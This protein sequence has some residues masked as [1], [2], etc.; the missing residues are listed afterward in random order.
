VIHTRPL[1]YF[2][3]RQI[4]VYYTKTEVRYRQ[5][6]RYFCCSGWSKTG[7]SCSNREP[8]KYL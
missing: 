2:Y 5:G 7:D 3:Y 1:S 4:T 8:F 6:Y